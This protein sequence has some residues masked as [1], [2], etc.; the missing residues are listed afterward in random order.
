M[1]AGR[2]K[3]I[4]KKKGYITNIT[5]IDLLTAKNSP[6]VY[7]GYTATG[8]DRIDNKLGHTK[9]NCVICCKE[10]NVARMDNFTHEEMFIIGNAIKHIK[11]A[12]KLKSFPKDK[13][14]Y[15]IF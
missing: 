15:P 10:C 8:F 7:C 14:G 12:R 3:M 2:Y 11:D 13:E 5:G 4:D 1:H 9:E 6:C